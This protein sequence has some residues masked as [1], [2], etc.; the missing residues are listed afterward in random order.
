MIVITRDEL[1][2][3]DEFGQILLNL[4]SLWRFLAMRTHDGNE[5]LT[6]LFFNSHLTENAHN[7]VKNNLSGSCPS[8]FACICKGSFNGDKCP[9]NVFLNRGFLC[10][11]PS[12][13]SFFHHNFVWSITQKQ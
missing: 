11:C 10:A 5:M 2:L 1:T 4:I 9:F 12:V 7:K 6:N 13:C 8:S 3:R